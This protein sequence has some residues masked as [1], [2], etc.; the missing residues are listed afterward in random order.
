MEHEE[1]DELQLALANWRIAE[2][3]MNERISALTEHIG[4]NAEKHFQRGL[5]LL[6]AELPEQARQEFLKTLRYDSKHK[7][8]LRYLKSVLN[9]Q[10]TLDYTVKKDDTFKTIAIQLYK[11]ENQ[12]VLVAFFSGCEDE[13]DLVAGRVITL[14]VLE[15]E[16]TKRFFN[17][18]KEM[19][20]A[21]KNFKDKAFDEV[22]P[23][24]ENILK[25]VPDNEE[26]M[27]MINSSYDGLADKL[28]KKQRY[29]EA[30]DML[31]RIDPKFRNVKSRIAEIEGFQARRRAVDT[32]NKNAAHYQDGQDFFKQE[33]YIEAL[34]AYEQVDPAYADVQDKI[35]ELK[36]LMKSESEIHYRKGV[37]FFL[38][39]RLD[40]AIQE[41]EQ[42]L[43]LDPENNKARKDIDNASLLL[44][45]I[46]EMN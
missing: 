5:T 41:W 46:N 31:K 30:I 17:F 28:V 23:I 3:L 16:F 10:R 14:P 36:A 34:K 12:D 18:H 27:F 13:K 42:T 26:A 44:K 9:P 25:H 32:E 45:K 15:V 1:K 33:M 6:N 20:L 19:G 40:E 4:N 39:E 2:A 38:N 11:N 7:E 21:R 8:A 29:S 24:A 37:K 22:L 35:L 43:A